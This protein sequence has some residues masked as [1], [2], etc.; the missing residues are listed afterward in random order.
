[1]PW[2]CTAPDCGTVVPTDT[3]S[4]PTC[5]FEKTAWTLEV[6]KTRQIVLGRRKKLEC[7]RGAVSATSASSP[8]AHLGVA[9]RKTD[10]ASVTLKSV[11][12]E[13]YRAG[14][15]PAPADLLCVRMFPKASL[16]SWELELSLEFEQR[17]VEE[18]ALQFER[19]P[20][21]L[22]PEGY[23]AAWFLCVYGEGPVDFEFPHIHVL[24]VSEATP[25]GHAPLLG[26]R[27]LRQSKASEVQLGAAPWEARWEGVAQST[28]PPARMIL[29]AQELS[30]GA[31]VEFE[32]EQLGVGVVAQREGRAE[33]GRCVLEFA[34]WY[35]H[36][37]APPE[38]EDLDLEQPFPQD[39][40]VFRARAMG[41]VAESEPLPFSDRFHA[42]LT[43]HEGRALGETSYEVVTPWGR[44][45]VRTDAAGVVDLAPL[46]PGGVWRVVLAGQALS[47]GGQQ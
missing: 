10:S 21:E 30:A 9:W 1:M 41:R 38:P 44:K 6:E 35:R 47:A 42:R 36:S 3:Q 14:R 24:D 37:L 23:F 4:C 16:K 45:R 11:A 28:A 25:L 8:L 29:E 22:G 33:S 26:V 39:Q 20:E 2:E 12:R 27:G 40:F 19:S 34:D 5:G 17:A 15:L 46:R 18:R 32:V 7:R 43:D 31:P 13:L